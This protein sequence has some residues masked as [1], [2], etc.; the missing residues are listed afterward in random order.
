MFY[1]RGGKEAVSYRGEKELE[2]LIVWLKET[3]TVLAN[4]QE[5]AESIESRRKFMEEQARQ[6]ELR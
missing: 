6:E 1:P 3:S 4:W 2:D 5:S